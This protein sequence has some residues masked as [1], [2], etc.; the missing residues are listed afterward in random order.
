MKELL[1]ELNERDISHRQ[2][3]ANIIDLSKKKR[4]KASITD[5]RALDNYADQIIKMARRELEK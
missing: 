3:L 4:R 1:D 5:N 2:F